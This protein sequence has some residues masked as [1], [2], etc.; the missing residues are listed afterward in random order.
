LAA[1]LSFFPPGLEGFF[2]VFSP[3]Y[4]ARIGSEDVRFLLDSVR[5]WCGAPAAHRLKNG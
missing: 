1:G 4:P 5:L 2:M 3:F